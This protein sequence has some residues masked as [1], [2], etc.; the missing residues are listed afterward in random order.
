MEKNISDMDSASNSM[1]VDYMIAPHLVRTAYIG[2]VHKLLD[3]ENLG[4][5]SFDDF[6]N[7]M[8]ISAIVANK[9][10]ILANDQKKHLTH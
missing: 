8:A 3:K 5:I 6:C 7:F 4:K 10:V 1:A 2:H 9:A